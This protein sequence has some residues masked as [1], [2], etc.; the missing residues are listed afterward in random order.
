[1]TTSRGQFCPGCETWLSGDVRFCPN[2]GE[3]QE[4]PAV[5]MVCISC[6]SVLPVGGRFCPQCGDEAAPP[7][8]SHTLHNPDPR[9]TSGDLSLERMIL[10]AAPVAVC[11]GS[12]GPWASALFITENGN[13]TSAGRA[14]LILSVV[15]FV[16]V[17]SATAPRLSRLAIGA[18]MGCMLIAGFIGAANWVDLQRLVASSEGLASVGW[19]LVVT[20]LA[21]W[22]G[23]VAA[24]I[25]MV[26]SREHVAT[27][28]N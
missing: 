24:F 12:L 14:T 16:C 2:C 6:G 27:G 9:K 21:A 7:E 15:A 26:R 20:T 3:R 4:R 18:A 5:S 11:I 22:G 28:L 23:V 10:L 13:Q 19:G 8:L 17:L 1:M 25:V